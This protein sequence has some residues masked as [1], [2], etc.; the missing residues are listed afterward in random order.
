MEKPQPTLADAAKT[1][2]EAFEQLMTALSRCEKS[3]IGAS[4]ASLDNE[5]QRFH[6]WAENLG[7][8]RP[9]HRS[10][11][12]RL[13]NARTIWQTVFAFLQDLQES[14]AEGMNRKSLEFMSRLSIAESD[15]D[16]LV[17]SCYTAQ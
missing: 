9:A 8:N 15:C 13:Q 7:L 11:D 16:Y 5:R 17:L 14:L 10:L 4:A 1:S 2:L 6:L 12:Y 3:E